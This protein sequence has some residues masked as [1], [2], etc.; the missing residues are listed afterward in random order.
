MKNKLSTILLISF[1]AVFLVAG[2]AMAAPVLDFSDGEAVGIGSIAYDGSNV[3]G[4]GIGLDQLFAG[5][6]STNSGIWDLS[7]PITLTGTDPNAAS[8]DFS[9]ATNSITIYGSVTGT[10]VGLQT[11]LTGTFSSWNWDNVYHVFNAIGFDTKCEDL[12]TYF[13]L[14]I[15]T[16]FNYVTFTLGWDVGLGPDEYLPVSVDY[17]NT[18]VPIP[19]TAWIFGAGLVC[20]VGIRRKL[21]S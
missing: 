9:T 2:S 11:L 13:G 16:P 6:V 1:L 17:R 19:A 10:S 20:L 5:G 4:T 14:G 15:G 7:G 18:P 3:T 12:L 21:K 8:L